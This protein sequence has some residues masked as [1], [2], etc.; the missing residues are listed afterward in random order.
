MPIPHFRGGDCFRI[1]N[2][3]PGLMV[4]LRS[5]QETRA[6]PTGRRATAF[7]TL[8][9][10]RHR[11][12]PARLA[13]RPALLAAAQGQFGTSQ[14]NLALVGGNAT[15]TGGTNGSLGV[16]GVA[17]DGAATAGNPV[18]VA[19]K[20]SGN[21]RVPIVC[22]NWTPINVA[23]TTAA[24][25]ITKAA[26]KNIYICSINLVVAAASNV[27]LIA[28]TQTTNQCDT[29]TAGL[30]GGATAA[31]GWNLAANGGLAYGSGIGAIAATATAGL[32]VCI[33]QS[34]ST[35]LSGAISWTQF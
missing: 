23:N 31:T 19:G 3:A 32:D 9:F 25:L 2:K 6:C 24:K 30:S 26:N 35:Q 20:G 12:E 17:G 15:A 16:G 10:V 13:G 28:G 29:S 34:A 18:L 5:P 8:A 33:V 22:D 4:R 11:L 21:T 1:I 27:A 7:G 14:I